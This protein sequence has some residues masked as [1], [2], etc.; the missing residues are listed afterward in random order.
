[1]SDTHA[2][3]RLLHLSDLHVRADREMESW[4]QRQLLGPAWEANLEAMLEDGPFDLVCFAGDATYQG[5]PE[6]L[7]EA[8]DCLLAL[9]ERLQLDRDRLFVVPGN[10]DIDREVHPRAWAALR[11]AAWEVDDLHL[12]R[13]LA[14]GAAPRGVVPQLREQV[15]ERQAAYRA[16]VHDKLG[17]GELDPTTS[18]HGLLGYRVR[19]EP[20]D[21]PVNVIGLDTA[22]LCGDDHDAARLWVTDEQVTRLLTDERGKPLEGLRLVLQHHP[23]EEL[24]D[25][26]RIRGLLAQ[27][28]DLV[29]RGHLHETELST[30]ADASQSLRQL[31]TGCLYEGARGD[32]WPN[33][34]LA[35]TLGLDDRGQPQQVDVRLRSY[36]T[37]SG[38]WF[39]DQSLYQEST[40]GR[41]S[42]TV[43]RRRP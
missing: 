43:P 28:A 5:R 26:R 15:L 6:E 30:W 8:G 23:L 3:F 16:W 25:G 39:D 42:W 7:E 33:A 32:R 19:L 40:D 18:P 34:C 4:R 17:R 12:A 21:V 20:G 10:H 31:A 22:W 29:L 24:A 1:M 9:I 35:V 13:W 2:R 27:R 36:S 14:G 41:L 38:H 11:Q 37:E